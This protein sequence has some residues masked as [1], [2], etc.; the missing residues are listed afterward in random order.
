MMIVL[1]Q[2]IGEQGI[3]FQYLPRTDDFIAL[4]LL[5]CFFISS[6]VLSRNK[7]HLLLQIK[8]FFNQRDRASIFGNSASIDIRFLILMLL[9]TAI[10][11]G[12]FFFNFFDDIS[13]SL[14]E[15]VS[16]Y[17]LLGG[18]IVSC[19]VYILLKWL[20]Y[21]LLGWIFF[22]K[23]KTSLWISSYFTLV[24]YFGFVLFPFV[25]LLIYFD[26]KLIYLVVLGLFLLL[27]VKILMFYK[28]IKLFFNKFEGLLLLILY[29]CALEIIP[30]LLLYR[31]MT[32]LNSLLI[33]KI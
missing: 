26:L 8:S 22:D 13:P 9:Q 17:L 12:L 19:A 5:V 10:F 21:V 30:C 15:N 24:C 18:Y 33:I 7:R 29:F 28:W 23:N 3:P 14:M 4:I 1:L 31:G 2:T 25:L 27:F 16:P 11:S 6:F 20:M 32:E